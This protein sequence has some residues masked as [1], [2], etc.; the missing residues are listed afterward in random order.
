MSQLRELATKSH[1]FLVD[2]LAKEESHL[3]PLI[4]Q[5]FTNDE[6]SDLVG[7][8]MGKRSSDNM[9][10]IMDISVENLPEDEQEDM[11]MHMTACMKGTFFEKWLSR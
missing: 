4:Q 10:Q 5:H 9:R 11:R 2:H 3:M 1:D 6:L 8:I 7:N